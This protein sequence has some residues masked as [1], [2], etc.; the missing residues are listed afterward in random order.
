MAYPKEQSPRTQYLHRCKASHCE[1]SPDFFWQSRRLV[2]A[3]TRVSGPNILF[4][5]AL[6]FPSRTAILLSS[7]RTPC[8]TSSATVKLRETVSSS[9]LKSRHPWWSHRVLVMILDMTEDIL[10]TA[11]RDW[12]GRDGTGRTGRDVY[13]VF[14]KS[15]EEFTEKRKRNFGE[16]TFIATGT[17]TN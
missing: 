5:T 15:E 1:H 3:T 8:I 2:L 10:K 17:R 9:R 12:T 11:E 13:R 16:D 4:A 6:C 7:D 14:E